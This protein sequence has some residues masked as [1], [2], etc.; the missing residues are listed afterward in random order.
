MQRVWL[1]VTELGLS[2]QPY[3]VVAD[4]MNRLDSGGIP[5]Q[6]LP[7]SRALK[8]RIHSKFGKDNTLHC[9][10]R[11][12]KPIGDIQF[13]GRLSSDEIMCNAGNRRPLN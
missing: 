1:K 8:E 6:C 2:A 10:L 3:Y 9:L 12:G 5:E 4:L 13:S 11:I 7:R